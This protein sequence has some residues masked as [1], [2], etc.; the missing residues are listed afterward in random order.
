M[1]IEIGIQRPICQPL[2]GSPIEKLSEGRRDRRERGRIHRASVARGIGRG[3]RNFQALQRIDIGTVRGIETASLNQEPGLLGV[4]FQARAEERR[5]LNR[6][7]MMVFCRSHLGEAG[8]GAGVIALP[9]RRDAQV[10][11]GFR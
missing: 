2:A 7:A 1:N 10:V 9:H 4:V 8:D 6:S 11:Q 3:Q 5:L